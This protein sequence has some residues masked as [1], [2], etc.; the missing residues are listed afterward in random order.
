MAIKPTKQGVGVRP[1]NLR[2]CV[3][4]YLLLPYS[5]SWREEAVPDLKVLKHLTGKPGA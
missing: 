4:G 5:N 3:G 1:E 2:S